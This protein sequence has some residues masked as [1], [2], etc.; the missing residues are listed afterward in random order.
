MPIESQAIAM[1]AEES[2]LSIVPAFQAGQGV[3]IAGLMALVNQAQRVQVIVDKA[4]DLIIAF[5]RIARHFTD[6][7]RGIA[8]A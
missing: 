6:L 5:T 8:A 1:G 7:E 4:Q 2:T 3:V